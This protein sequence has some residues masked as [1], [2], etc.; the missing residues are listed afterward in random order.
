MLFL[1]GVEVAARRVFLAGLTR[2]AAGGNSTAPDWDARPHRV[3]FL[4]H[5]RIGDMVVSTAMLHVIKRA[6]ANVELHVL[7]SP[8]NAPVV[9]HDPAVQTVVPF[10]RHSLRDYA[11]LLGHFRRTRYDVVVDPMVFNQSLTTLLLILATRAPHRVGV[12]KPGRPNVYTMFAIP[13]DH[14]G[15]PRRDHMLE[16]LAQLAIPFGV[17]PSD[18]TRMTLVVTDAERALA[19]KQWE[20]G[21]RLLVNVSAGEELRRWPDDRYVAIVRHL[22]ER[23]PGARVLVLH[24]P[25]DRARA[26]VIARRAGVERADTASLRSAMALVAEAEFVFTPDTSIVHIAGALDVPT[27]ALFTFDEVDRWRPQARINR[28]AV[29]LGLTMES[30]SLDDARRA[31]DEVLTET[32]LV[33]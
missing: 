2:L 26:D 21:R 17:A 20:V 5:D 9:A 14:H 27:V 24:G 8:L 15:D 32:H 31:V 25:A 10:N 13:H 1:K 19:R 29:G 30:V 4:R 6:H 22:L 7:A 33:N 18:A 23:V 28:V 12:L 3:L 16:Y 11:R